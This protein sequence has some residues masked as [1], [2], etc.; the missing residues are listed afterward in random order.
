MNFL[1]I[2]N[3]FFTFFFTIFGG[4]FIVIIIKN[5]GIDEIKAILFQAVA[6]NCDNDNENDND[7]SGYVPNS[8]TEL[9]V[10]LAMAFSPVPLSTEQV[11]NKVANSFG[12][13]ISKRSFL[14]AH[15]RKKEV[16]IYE[17]TIN[18][19]RFYRINETVRK[20][21]LGRIINSI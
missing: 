12:I 20:Q 5:M 3:F 14:E 7:I 16:F 15:Y 8:I 11:L 18:R 21:V 6:D 10:A 19:T 13:I 2:T 17:H 9:L 4:S 1:Q